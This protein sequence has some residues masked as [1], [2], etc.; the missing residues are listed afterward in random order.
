[1]RKNTTLHNAKM[2]KKDEFYTMYEDIENE[3]MYYKEH[4]TDKIIY[5]NC[6]NPD[7]SNF[8]KY[9]Y[10]NF[11]NL[12]LKLLIS[13]YYDTN[14]NSYKTEYDGTKTTKTKL[15]N[16][17]DFR[18]EECIDILKQSD[19]I[20]TNPPFSLFREYINILIKHNKKF[21]VWGSINM[22]PYK[23]VFP[24]I[25]NEEIW[26]GCTFNKTCIFRVPNN[27]EYDKTTT[28]KIN[29]N[30]KY[31]KFSNIATFTN[32][33]HN[34]KYKH[35]ELN[36]L[37]N[38]TD[39]P[40][41]D[42]YDAINVDRIKDIPINYDGIM[43]VPITYLEHHNPD[44]FKIIGIASGNAWANFTE[45]L[46]SLNF[47]PNIKY[48]GGLGIGIINKKGKYARLLIQKKSQ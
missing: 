47:N 32:I 11:H 34:K 46:K 2:N 25:M 44:K 29:D 42:N 14:N 16:N 10:D 33:H 39:Y 45:I 5:Y 23:T 20:V 13:T 40:K 48:G 21:I 31:R 35:I 41:Y 17:G 8:W 26:V 6:D 9:F 19:I 22:I 3:L 12:K 15:N 7:Y 38:K 37:Y 24:L 36:K 18:S 30:H 28:E 27:Y 43:G 4:L 1:M